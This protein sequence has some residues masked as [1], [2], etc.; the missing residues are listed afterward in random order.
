MLK[1]HH[2]NAL[3]TADLAPVLTTI[4]R[5]IS[6]SVIISF[7]NA[8]CCR[9]PFSQGREATRPWTGPIDTLSRA[10]GSTLP[11]CRVLQ[12]SSSCMLSSLGVVSQ[13]YAFPD[14]ISGVPDT[15]AH[16][17]PDLLG[18]HGSE[19]SLKS[20]SVNCGWPFATGHQN[21][22]R[23][24]ACWGNTSYLFAYPCRRYSLLPTTGQGFHC[25]QFGRDC[26]GFAWSP[27]FE[28]FWPTW[29]HCSWIVRSASHARRWT[30]SSYPRSGLT[31]LSAFMPYGERWQLHRRFLHQTFRMDS[32]QRFLPYQHRMACQLLRQ[33]LSTPGQFAQHAVEYVS[34]VQHSGEDDLTL[35]QDT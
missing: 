1:L 29:H 25:R 21:T 23:G 26:K 24:A 22:V 12:S 30:D 34:D 33:L 31:D 35:H 10:I 8:S 18:Y 20:T 14:D 5:T 32:T 17:P 15:P 19:I 3:L 4:G 16:C 13:R 9:V 27:F 6:G 2:D 7:A 11:Q 28:P